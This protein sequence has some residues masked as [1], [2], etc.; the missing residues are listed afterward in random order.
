MVIPRASA[1]LTPPR[2][3]LSC[4]RPV[5]EARGHTHICHPPLNAMELPFMSL[6]A[7]TREA[8][9]RHCATAAPR[10]CRTVAPRQCGTAALWHCGTAALHHCGITALGT[11]ARTTGSLYADS[12]LLGSS[13]TPSH[14]R[15]CSATEIRVRPA[16]YCCSASTLCA[17]GNAVC[18]GWDGS[19]LDGLRGGM[20]FAEVEINEDWGGRMGAHDNEV[21]NVRCAIPDRIRICQCRAGNWASSLSEAELD[22]ALKRSALVRR[23]DGR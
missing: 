20:S 7:T 1:H 6:S 22:K 16:T 9:P 3:V 17:A 23:E 12:A 4:R 5:L 18:W 13:G 8:K 14:M 15:I 21:S 2:G 10:C 11:A 19:V